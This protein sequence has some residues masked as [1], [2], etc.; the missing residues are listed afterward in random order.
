[1]PL[2]GITTHCPADPDAANLDAL[3]AGI[4]QGVERAGGWRAAAARPGPAALRGAPRLMGLFSG[5]GDL[6]PAS[7]RPAA[8]GPT[9][10]A[11]APS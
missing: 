3:L 9:R 7:R 11:M 10:P 5:G 2:I 6:D 8:T 1:M 4:V